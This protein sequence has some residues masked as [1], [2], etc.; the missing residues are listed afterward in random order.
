MSRLFS[1][2]ITL[3]IGAA[4]ALFI[5]FKVLPGM[6]IN[7]T[8]SPLSFDETVEKIEANAKELGWKVPKKWKANFQANFIKVLDFDIGPTKLIK[9]CEPQAAVDIL[10]HDRYK[11]LAVMMPCTVAVYEKS[12][13]KVYIGT[14]NMRLLGMMFGGEVNKVIKRIAPQM[15]QMINL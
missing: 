12:D 7:E 13:G 8:L 9:M 5:G 6:M 14:M 11:S 10:K 1:T 2:L 15:D 3:F 4:L